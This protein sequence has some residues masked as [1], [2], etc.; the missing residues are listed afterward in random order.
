[1]LVLIIINGH[2]TV[3]SGMLS[4]LYELKMLSRI[5]YHVALV[6]T[7]VLSPSSGFLRMI[8]FHSCV[9]METLLLSLFIE[10]YC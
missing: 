9:T 1:M 2:R 3:S 4:S 10:G 7:D 5:L 6:R 8:G